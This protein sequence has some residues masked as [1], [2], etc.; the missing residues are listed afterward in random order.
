MF[1][2]FV[3]LS[4][5]VRANSY[6][7]KEISYLSIS[8][9]ITPA[10]L[11]YLKHQFKNVPPNSIAV[12]QMNTPGGLVSTTKEI[13]TLF[14]K[15]DFPIAVWI[16]PEGASASSAG[17]IIAA[18]AH[19]ILMAPGTNLGA[20]TPVGLGED[21]KESDGRKKVLND[22]TALVRSLSQMRGRPAGPFEAMVKDAESFTHKEALGLKIIDGVAS[23]QAEIIT[24][25]A[26]KKFSQNGKSFDLS[27]D[28]SVSRKDYGP[29]VG[30]KILEVI[31]NPSTAYILFLL[32]VALIYFELQAPG[33]YV[34]GS[35]G[36][37]CLIL[38]GVSFQV[39]PL[40]WGALGL[41]LVGIFLLIL[42]I[43]IVSYGLLTILGLISFV[44]GS[45]F[46]FHGEAGYISVE[47]PVMFS[48][49]TGVIAS[50]GF[51]FWYLFKEQKKLGKTPDFFMPVGS[52]GTVVTK[53][54]HLYQVKVKGETWKAT[55]SDNLN[56]GDEVEISS[57]DPESLS[58]QV[59]KIDH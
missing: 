13:I 21:L 35:L 45:L 18:A 27:F 53:S 5:E 9:A 6:E 54:A 22:L 10:T 38:A 51:I 4:P 34:A 57:V 33:G 20:A 19:F 2:L 12:I 26:G 31:A 37:S 32:G 52:I 44:L 59:K 3:C 47:Y 50:L 40:D 7:V 25:L 11:D 55:S 42:E 49:L 16:S 48:A 46:L 17:A 28:K 23:G 1:S 24:I 15:Q 14:A 58:I 41:I 29:T 30:Q 56:I 43:F 8:S 39:L 36:L